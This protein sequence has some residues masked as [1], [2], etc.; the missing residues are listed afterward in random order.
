VNGLR[1]LRRQVAD[2]NDEADRGSQ[3]K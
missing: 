2:D 3:Q 1:F